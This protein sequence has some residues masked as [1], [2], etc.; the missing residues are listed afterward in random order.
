M[1]DLI[2]IV[3]SFADD[4]IIWYFLALNSFYALLLL[5]SVPEIWKHWKVV[6]HEDL[7][8]Y[9][10]L[11]AL[12]PIS[13][14]IPAH[15]MAASVIH[16][17]DAQL[18]LEY[19][20]HEVIV[21]DDGSTDDT[22]QRLHEA[23]DLYE[24]PPA[25]PAH[26]ETK[27]IRGYY[28][29]RTR[30]HLLVVEKDN[31]GKADALNAGI[32][33]ARYPLVVAVDADTIVARD[34]LLR[35]ARPF[36]LGENVAAAGGTI[37]V[38]NGAKIVDGQ[39]VEAR[40]PNR[41]L[42]AVQV[43]EYL[44]AFLFGRLGWNRLGGNLIVSGAFGLFQRS[45]LLAIGGYRA[46]NVVEDL[47][48][49]V[50]LHQHL[51]TN[52]IAYDIPFVPDPVAWTEV[53]ADLQSHR[54]QRARWHR[55]LV[56]TMAQ[57]WKMLFNRKYG[58]IGFVTVPFFV[59][60]EML[61][62]LVEVFGY[63]LTIVGLSLG[64][65][66]LQYAVLFLV[67]AVGYQM[68]LSIWA[69]V[70]EET[71]FKLYDRPGDFLRLVGYAIAE[72]FGYRQITVLW[73]LLGFWQALR[74]RKHWG[75]MKRRGFKVST[76]FTIALVVMLGSFAVPAG[77]QDVEACRSANTVVNSG[78]ERFRGNNLNAARDL[79]SQALRSCPTHIGAAV[80]MGFVEL[81]S[82][83]L[84]AADVRFRSILD[85]DSTDV[86]SWVGLGIVAWQ[87][88]DRDVARARLERALE[89]DPGNSEA[90]SYL[91]QLAAEEPPETQVEV[92]DSTVLL[93]ELR[94]LAR[95]LA[96]N[97]QY[98]S[99][100]L[101]YERVI[102][103]NR[104]DVEARKGLARTVGW[105]GDHAGSERL[106]QAILA[107]HPDDV[108]A[109]LGLAQVRRW[110]GRLEAADS[111]LVNAER[112]APTDPLVRQERLALDQSRAA[113]TNP[114][115]IFETDSDGNEITTLLLAAGARIHRR[116]F[117][118]G[119]IV[120]RSAR[121]TNSA[122]GTITSTTAALDGTYDVDTR[123]S[124]RAGL[125]LNTSSGSAGNKP[126]LRAGVTGPVWRAITPRL[127]YR[128]EPL[129]VTARLMANGV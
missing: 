127:D 117:L 34:A 85:R 98:D 81:R 33:S 77:A 23:Y 27:H 14:L 101:V 50:R 126:V 105:S 29:S 26:I 45:Y 104:S 74:G 60:G 2:A 38:A 75:A 125:G 30:P 82:G 121:N 89:L 110:Q 106:W 84:D 113:T 109:Q 56:V 67:A 99:A 94:S 53:P 49:V 100:A 61:A 16:S 115:V 88:S 123:W 35:L 32:N 96:L 93:A 70:L 129:D 114:F 76:W 86:D 63:A 103:G 8:S 48:L 22:F 128:H 40:I 57:H 19:P 28:R 83:D 20:Q 7:R 1:R 59:F 62:P 108:E 111:A 122:A 120:F 68:F 102:E 36:L 31:G 41:F 71:T 5:L 119:R 18:A 21:V 118:T 46:G 11:E 97:E 91:D 42:A 47:D 24:V 54:R 95:M 37:R 52:K 87:R 55:G 92:V 107:D 17:V 65:V 51:R 69:V 15:N 116:V 73:R 124:L 72:P 39:V 25:F 79:F 43:P 3:I 64:L 112:L 10:G 58:T 78:W 4:T 66:D 80:G 9:L 6:H 90:Q 44:R 13:V 12:P